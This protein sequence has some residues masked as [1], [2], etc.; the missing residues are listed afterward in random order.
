[1]PNQSYHHGDLKAELIREGLRLLDRE[2][3]EGFSLRKVAGACGVSQTA[4]YRHF[5]DKDELITAIMAEA[6]R[7]FNDCLEEAARRHPEEPK[8]RLKAIGAAYV[9]F[10]AG[11]P[12][13]LR[14]LFL[15]DVFSKVNAAEDDACGNPCDQ[16]NHFKDGHPFYVFYK[17]I[18]DYI[19]AYPDGPMRE[20]ELLLYCWG[21]V[22]GISVLIG[23]K[24]KLPF[25]DPI[26]IA[27]RLLENEAFL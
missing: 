27:E 4:P 25:S 16:E 11:N 22:H 3:Y 24:E 19:A 8:V 15:S 21:L 10:F 9:R 5:K 17:A 14:L 23:N 6:M 7:S 12:E 20:D 18:R 13:Y 2:G 26:S 1:V